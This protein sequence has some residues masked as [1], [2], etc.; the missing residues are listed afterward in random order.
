MAVKEALFSEPA[1]AAPVAVL[2]KLLDNRKIGRDESNVCIITGA[3]LK[4]V[5]P[6][7]K[8]LEAP[9]TIK[10]DIRALK[11]LLEQQKQ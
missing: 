4:D 9:P 2:K 11:A 10:P 7:E 5:D 6:L 3:G 8:Y 1:S